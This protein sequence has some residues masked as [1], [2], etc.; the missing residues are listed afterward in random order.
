MKLK[1]SL[2]ASSKPLGFV[3]PLYVEPFK[4]GDG[5]PIAQKEF[6]K[7][8]VLCAISMNPKHI[9]I[10]PDILV[11]EVVKYFG[12]IVSKNNHS[13]IYS[14]DLVLIEKVEKLW[15]VIHQKRCVFATRVVSLGFAKGVATHMA[16]K[17]MN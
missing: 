6:A 9:K 13:Y 3:A 14:Q 10:P 11:E 16:R 8:F 5:G 4:I 15:M 7:R 12:P 1:P 2:K 17:Q